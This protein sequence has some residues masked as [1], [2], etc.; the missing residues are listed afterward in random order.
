ME[1]VEFVQ[2]V[3]KFNNNDLS[4]L[5][6]IGNLVRSGFDILD[7]SPFVDTK[8]GYDVNMKILFSKKIKEI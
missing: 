8:S 7:I 5:T 1:K 2:F 3:F 4:H 6:E